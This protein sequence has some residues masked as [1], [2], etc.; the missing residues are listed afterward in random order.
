MRWAPILAI[1]AALVA[2]IA[3]GEP[4]DP[5]GVELQ[6]HAALSALKPTSGFANDPCN[7]V[8]DLPSDFLEA[9]PTCC[10]NKGRCVPEGDSLGS[11]GDQLPSCEGGGKCAPL[12]VLQASTKPPKACKSPGGAGVCFPT[13]I[14]QIDRLKLVLSQENCDPD[15]R[16]VPCNTPG[17]ESTGLCDLG[18][19]KKDEPKPE[20]CKSRPKQKPRAELCAEPPTVVDVTKLTPCDAGHCIPRSAA[21]EDMVAQLAPCADEN[22]VCAPDKQI[23]TGGLFT[24]KT[25]KSIGGAEGRCFS[26]AI[27]EVKEQGDRLPK[28]TCADDE[29]CTPC[30]DPVSGEALP[31][32]QTPCDAGPTQEKMI[33]AS[34]QAEKGRCVPESALG[35]GMMSLALKLDTCKKGE[36]CAPLAAMNRAATPKLCKTKGVFSS[37]ATGVCMEAVFSGLVTSFGGL[38]GVSKADC[39][40]DFLCVPCDLGETPLKGC[41]AKA[42]K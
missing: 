25:C 41:P 31:S 19:K 32:C 12:A 37:G 36:K 38:L 17:G 20:S 6:N 9:L 35:G 23:A 1:S 34:C 5:Y 3:C 28:D 14:D 42:P 10:N 11:Q 18:K 8:P 30:F 21:G 26:A 33:F 4:P 16:C 27:G 29:R 24:P 7:P 13:C 2:T 39:D 15:E 22:Y 40:T